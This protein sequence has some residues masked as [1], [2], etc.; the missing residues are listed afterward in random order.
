MSVARASSLM[1]LRRLRE[2]GR[3]PAPRQR[4]GRIPPRQMPEGAMR[5]YGAALVHEISTA[6]RAALAEVEPELI[7]LLVGLR[8]EQGRADAAPPDPR[9]IAAALAAAERIGREKGAAEQRS[10]GQA[11]AAA[12][13]RGAKAAELIDHA[14]RAFARK[15]RP[16]E[17]HDVVKKFGV[18]AS[19]HSR[20]QLDRQ[21]RS[22]IGVP[23]SAI[24]R[25]MQNELG[26]WVANNVA[27]IRTVPE[28]YFDRVQQ[29]VQEAFAG[30]THPETLRAQLADRYAMSERD[31][32][33]IA[34]DQVLKLS[35]DLT[36]ARM[37][38]LGV[39]HAR[40]RTMR[41]NRVSDDCWAREGKIYDL[42]TGINGVFPG[43]S[44]PVCRCWPEPILDDLLGRP[45]SPL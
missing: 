40:W 38:S 9:A 39:T 3:L 20:D 35:A 12:H 23:L 19:E 28:R 10:L 32:E 33:R 45:T 27:L 5:E 15:L 7:A 24:E 16:T 4:V 1:M 6:A 37:S 8:Q 17:L 13:W 21:L 26:A 2:I 25:P 43:K 41:D 44:H 22:A 34:R 31:A 36:H 29:D 11:L 42:A 30:G 18:R 14:A